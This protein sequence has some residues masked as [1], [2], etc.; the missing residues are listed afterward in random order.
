MERHLL[1]EQLTALPLGRS[2]SKATW[3]SGGSSSLVGSMTSTRARC[4]KR[5]NIQL[6]AAASRQCG[7][8]CGNGFL[9]PP[10]GACR[11]V[12]LR[13]PGSAG[14]GTSPCSTRWS[15]SRSF[16]ACYVS[17]GGW[18][19]LGSACRSPP[20]RSVL[21]CCKVRHGWNGNTAFQRSAAYATPSPSGASSRTRFRLEWPA[22]R[23]EQ[24][25]PT[26]SGANGGLSS[27]TAHRETSDPAS[28]VSYRPHGRG[29]LPGAE[30]RN[31]RRRLL[32]AGARPCPLTHCAREEPKQHRHGHGRH[33]PPECRR[34]CHGIHLRPG[35]LV[36]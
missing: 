10:A 20:S 12:L 14:T 9:R 11:P 29:L 3:A 28:C 13:E 7:A 22:S 19:P 15:A 17:G 36:S 27:G 21:L 6:S 8:L 18:A 1:V 26:R 2:N 31:R 34:K 4:G 5:T 32:P 33:C 25:L 30:R 23:H 24:P 16:P 35:V